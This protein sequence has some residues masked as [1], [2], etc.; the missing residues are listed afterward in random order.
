IRDFHVTGVQ[1]CALPISEG[2]APIVKA[3]EAGER[4]ADTWQ[5]AH[6]IAPGIRVPVAIADYLILDAVRT[7]GG[8][9]IAVSDDEILA[10]MSEKIGRASCRGRGERLV[11]G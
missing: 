10:A 11:G 8:T 4:H 6:T 5:D 1:T 9:A 7:S 3:Y 2:C